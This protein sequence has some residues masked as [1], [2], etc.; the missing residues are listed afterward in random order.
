MDGC[1]LFWSRQRG[2]GVDLA[3]QLVG[4]L[5]ELSEVQ[6]QRMRCV[7]VHVLKQKLA[8]PFYSVERRA[9]VMTQTAMEGFERFVFLTIGRRILDE[10]F[11][12]CVQLDARAAHPVEIG[13]HAL[14]LRGARILDDHVEQIGDGS[15][16]RLHL[17]SE[18]RRQGPA[19]AL[20]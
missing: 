5:F 8:V 14:G 6:S 2:H 19:Q 4:G 11:H 13:E 18:E 20:V 17:L 12:E 7:R 10:A 3:E 15:G 9:Q 16:R 1:R